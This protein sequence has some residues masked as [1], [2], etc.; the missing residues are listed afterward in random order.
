[1]GASPRGANAL[2]RMSRAMAVL[3]GRTFV[4]PEDIAQVFNDVLGHRVHLSAKARANGLTVDA[5]L[6]N[7]KSSVKVPRT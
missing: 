4:T 6:V 5:A 7:I 2:L 3:N 1:M